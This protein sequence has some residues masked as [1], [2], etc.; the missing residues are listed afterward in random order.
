MTL[1]LVLIISFGLIGYAQTTV[2]SEDIVEEEDSNG[3]ILN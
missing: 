3:I 1:F 2:D